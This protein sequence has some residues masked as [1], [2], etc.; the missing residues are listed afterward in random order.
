MN[1]NIL[2]LG[3][4]VLAFVY[5]QCQ[6]D[7]EALLGSRDHD[8]KSVE[9]QY[10]AIY[11]DGVS[12]TYLLATVFDKDGNRADS[13]K[14]VFKTDAGTLNDQGDEA[15]DITDYM[16][17]AY[18]LLTSEPSVNDIIATVEA[19][20]MSAD[21]SSYKKATEDEYYIS[22]CIQQGQA[23]TNNQTLKKATGSLANKIKIQVRFVGVSMTTSIEDTL[24]PADGL[25]QT[26]LTVTL[27]ETE[28]KAPIS[29]AE[30]YL[31]AQYGSIP[32]TINTNNLG[33][34]QTYI[35][36]AKPENAGPDTLR[37]QYG[38][39]IAAILYLTYIQPKF[40][41]TTESTQTLADGK[42]VIKVVATLLTQKNTPVIGARVFFSTTDG[43]IPESA[44]TDA[45]GQ[46]KVDLI[47]SK[48]A[49][50][51]VSVI[52]NY[53]SLRDTAQ[54]EFITT[55]QDFPNSILLAAEPNFVWVRETGNLEQTS[56]TA[57]VLGGAGLPVGNDVRVRFRLENT[58][59]GG[60][61]LDP[62]SATDPMESDI[63]N[64]VNGKATINVRSGIRSGTVQV[65]AQLIDYP[66]IKAQTTNI[67]IRSGPPYMWVDPTNANNIIPHATMSVEPG[68]AN[69]AFGN[70]IQSIDIG[71]IFGDKYNNPVEKGTAIYFTTTGGIIS[72]DALT[73]AMGAAAVKIQNVY[74]YPYLRTSD[75]NQLTSRF[76]PN[77]NDDQLYIGIPALDYTSWDF[78]GGRVLNTVGTTIENDGIALL[79]AYTW[80]VNQN[81]EPIKVWTSLPLIFSVGVEEFSVTT[82]TSDGINRLYLGESA[83]INIRVWD[84]HGNPVAAGSRL[85]VK[86]TAGQISEGSLMPGAA[87]YGYG[88]TYFTTSLVNSLDPLN[89]TSQNA[90]VTITLETA[91]GTYKRQ[92]AIYLDISVRL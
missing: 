55:L 87:D 41:L 4:L 53:W 63:M 79:I 29:D 57:T 37:I 28:S 32:R 67:V 89:D 59:G 15:F 47:P 7:P 12:Q 8:I 66:Q 38:T 56:V 39:G 24:L 88:T 84:R 48:Q 13:M 40:D 60:L 65:S 1:K 86:T 70:P 42:S 21:F 46:A 18:V 2:L 82:T 19:T 76:V 49:N 81:N 64:T 17:E 20:V 58:P 77:P 62:V 25:S 74:P 51:A 83:T 50:P 45:M 30:I 92:V 91:F 35:T 71:T 23:G 11:A 26:Q 3:L 72:T 43:I 9:T 16:G 68:K 80:G 69:T 75:P 27:Q 52:A 33:I 36:A 5:I 34:A 31:G 90:V 44:S 14:V 6:D 85:S 61:T 78:E 10:D 22:L 73:D 54:V